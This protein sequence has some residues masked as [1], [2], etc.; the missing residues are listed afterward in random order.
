MLDDDILEFINTEKKLLYVAMSRAKE[1]L[2]LIANGCA[3]EKQISE[4]IFDFNS[5]D[6]VASGFTKSNIELAKV[7]Y[8]NLGN[9]K[10]FVMKEKEIQE[11]IK[12]EFTKKME[13]LRENEKE[14]KETIIKVND[15]LD[16]NYYSSTGL[17]N[18]VT[19]F[20]SDDNNSVLKQMS[21]NI[22]DKMDESFE[23]KEEK[24]EIDIIDSI[25][26]PLLSKHKIKFVDKRSMGGAFWIIAG[27]EIS[28]LVESFNSY[29]L[30]LLFVK[31]GRASTGNKPAWYT[32]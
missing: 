9:G 5:K 22:N 27:M 11:I 4:F 10:L 20:E 25:V 30:K 32:K 6:Y 31:N 23:V 16:V 24:I 1:E 17:M 14:E 26:K 19:I 3:S 8:N 28:N 7:H 18:N 2:Y 21:L 15:L 13:A 12:D 29:G